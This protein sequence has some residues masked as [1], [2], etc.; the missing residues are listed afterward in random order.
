MGLA[1]SNIADGDE[2][3][4]T[5]FGYVR[6]IKTNYSTWAEGDVLYL[7]TTTAGALTNVQPSAPHHSDIVGYVGIIGG[8]GIGSILV[9][10]ERHQTLEELSDVD[11]TPLAT[12][13]QIPVWNNTS[14]Y[15]DFTGNILGPQDF[16][17]TTNDGSTYAVVA[18]D[19]DNNVIEYI[20]SDGFHQVRYRDEYPSGRWQTPTGAS[21]PDTVSVTIA[22]FVTDCW[23]FD[24]GTTE[25]VTSNNFEGAHD[26]PW[27]LINNGTLPL[28]VH[29]HWCQSTNGA[30]DVKW[31]IPMVLL[32]KDAA[33]VALTTAEITGTA[34]SNQQYYMRISG[35][36]VTPPVGG[37]IL[38]DIIQ[39]NVRRTPTATGDTYNADAL[40]LQCALH[41]PSDGNGSRQQYIR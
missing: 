36:T 25:E 40:F 13:G 27:H 31:F 21:A 23:A 34:V 17:A 12:T 14:G 5:S 2:G 9:K 32:R 4:I 39:F 10:I 8:A 29:V 20:D 28:E 15:F 6:G 19:S 30:G 3:Y 22:G 24:G 16:K 38:G 41:V 26:V 35:A 37:F 7:S 11:S 1:T 33:P 18:R